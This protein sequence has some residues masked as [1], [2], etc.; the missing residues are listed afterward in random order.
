MIFLFPTQ[1]I[2]LLS[3]NLPIL[4]PFRNLFLHALLSFCFELFGPRNLPWEQLGALSC[5]SGTVRALPCFH[6]A[7][8]LL[9]HLQVP[10][11][12]PHAAVLLL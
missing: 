7:A 2:L 3:G 4:A 11:H 5:V 10:L 12:I 8:F 9:P 6:C 1:V